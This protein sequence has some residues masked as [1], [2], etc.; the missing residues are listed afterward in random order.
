MTWE[1]PNSVFKTVEIEFVCK[2]QTFQSSLLF[3]LTMFLS[4]GEFSFTIELLVLPEQ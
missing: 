1:F 4:T 3:K 2:N